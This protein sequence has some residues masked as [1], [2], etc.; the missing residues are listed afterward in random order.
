MIPRFKPYI[1]WYEFK[2]LFR[3]NKGA[4]REFE[5]QFASDFDAVDAVAFPYG[6]SA[7]WA[8]FKAIGLA[9]SDIIMPAYTCSV[10]AHAVTLSGNTPKFIDINLDDY[11]MDLDAVEDAVDKNTRGIIATHTFGYPQDLERLEKIISRAEKRFNHKIWL[12]QDCCHAFGANWKGK[13]IGSSGDVAVYAFNISKLMTSIFGGMLTFQDQEL[14]NTVREWRDINYKPA[15][16]IKGLK[17]RIYLL[18]VYVAFHKKV[19]GMTWWLQYKTKLLDRFTIAHHLDDKIHFPDDYLEMMHDV[20]AA[21]GLEQLKKYPEII[22]KRRDRVND[23]HQTLPRRLGWVFPPI[24][25]G[26]T[27]SHY[28]VRVPDRNSILH[29]YA[30]AGI[31]C[32]ELIQY[33]IPALCSYEKTQSHSFPN[34][35][36]ASKETINFPL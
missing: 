30:K 21:V 36:K 24:V 11:N 4:V 28:T 3:R 10:V 31:H 12:I 2:A 19:Y 33:S 13:K 9:K 25:D 16:W 23:Y 6:R 7:Q 35:T 27:F 18:L 20:E 8:F 5:K 29:E 15:R 14:A 34:S 22:K 17:R 26:T 32:G 1:G